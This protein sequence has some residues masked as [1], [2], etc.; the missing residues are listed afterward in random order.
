MSACQERLE[1]LELRDVEPLERL[2][3]GLCLERLGIGLPE[4]LSQ[5]TA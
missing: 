3:G 2:E 4:R 5:K 1:P